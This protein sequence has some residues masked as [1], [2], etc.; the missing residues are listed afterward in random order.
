[1]NQDV[2]LRHPLLA[3]VALRRRPHRVLTP[4]RSVIRNNGLGARPWRPGCAL[5]RHLRHGVRH[6]RRGAKR[7]FLGTHPSAWSHNEA[8]PARTTGMVIHKHNG[9][10][11]ASSNT[12]MIC[13]TEGR[14]GCCSHVIGWCVS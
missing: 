7:P 14:T 5:A 11:E 13:D 6:C 8:T 9:W 4:E 3:H 12:R 1:V 10:H 2:H